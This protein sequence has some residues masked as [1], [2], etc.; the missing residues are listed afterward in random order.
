[1][2]QLITK[3]GAGA[4]FPVDG[5]V[6]GSS[7]PDGLP[8]NAL[9][10]GAGSGAIVSD[11]IM[12]VELLASSVPSQFN[13]LH[14]IIMCF[15]TT[16]IPIGST[17]TNAAVSL[18]CESKVNGMSDIAAYLVSVTPSSFDNL[19]S[20]DYPKVNSLNGSVYFAS[21]NYINVGTYHTSNLPSKD[22]YRINTGGTTSF[23]LKV[24]FP[25]WVSGARSGFSFYTADQGAS[26]APTLTVNYTPP[27]TV[28]SFTST[29][30][31]LNAGQS[32]TFADTSTNV[33]TSWLWDFGDGTTS[34]LKN[35]THAYATVGQFTVS[36]T[37]T[38]EGGNNTVTKTNLITTTLESHTLIFSDLSSGA[39]TLILD[40][41]SQTGIFSDEANGGSPTGG[42]DTLYISTTFQSL[43]QKEYEYRVFDEAGNYIS[44]WQDVKSDFSYSQRVNENATE[45]NVMIGRAPDNRIAKLE[46]LKDKNGNDILDSSSTII[47]VSTET[48]NSVGE[49]TDIREN[50]NVEVYCFYGGYEALK[51]KNG[52][53]ILDNLSNVIL[54]GYGNPNGKRVYTGY[55]ADYDL[56]YGDVTGVDVV[57]APFA[58]EMSHYIFKSGT[59][60]TVN[61]GL[62]DPIVM[63][64]NAMDNYIAQGGVI[65][66]TAESM[67]LSG[68][69]APYEFNLQTTRASIDKT[70]D[71]LPSGY[72]HYVHPG[73]NVQYELQKAVTAHHTFYYEKHITQLKLKKSITQLINKVYFVGGETTPGVSLFKYYEDTASV[74]SLRPGLEILSD[75]RVIVDTSASILSN[76]KIAEFKTAR[77]R[78][79]VVITDAV[80]D[81]ETIKLGQMV[82]FKNFGTFADTLVL[83]IV[84]ID[85]KK[86]SV[87]L[88][89]DMVIPGEAKRLEDLK[90]AILSE[91]IANVGTTPT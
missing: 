41:Q 19:I 16:S 46:A 87:N 54:T 86:H 26:Y 57:I 42:G 8:A 88:D 7:Y 50:L 13:E 12:R 79:S 58:T 34:T 21:Y 38:N 70:V 20:S 5:E 68:E 15:D 59:A 37:A 2:V 60:T 51:D 90:R 53:D 39:D 80:Y 69:Q 63:A 85:R 78:T 56:T 47:Y 71:L 77:W 65:T 35:P 17:I 4:N 11:N 1:M 82:D 18:Y 32:V 83:Q 49:G 76:R 81:I 23:G 40:F 10:V 52:N 89:L 28:A 66:Y 55:I 74:S 25:Q 33:P 29:P 36:L 6:Y 75:S 45:L 73:E 84:G 30:N 14:H 31:S 61:Y 62:T 9:A 24:A 72:Y 44:T 91:Q 3:T 22:F 27:A 64:R 67:P 48:E 43:P